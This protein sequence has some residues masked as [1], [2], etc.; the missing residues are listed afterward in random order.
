M[1][2]CLEQPTNDFLDRYHRYGDQI[3]ARLV[4]HAVCLSWVD[5]K[6]EPDGDGGKES[7]YSP[8]AFAVSAFVV[9]IRGIWFL[10]T[11]GHILKDLQSRLSSGRRILKSRLFAGLTS[12][13]SSE[14]IPFNLGDAPQWYICED[15]M[16]YAIIPFRPAFVNPLIAD[17]VIALNKIHWTN[18]PDN[19]GEYYLLGFP[20][21]AQKL[22]IT[23][24]GDT[25]NVNIQ[26]GCPLLPVFPVSDPPEALKQKHERFYAKVPFAKGMVDDPNVPLTDIDGMS[27]GPIFVLKWID[28]SNIESWVFAVQ[29]SWLKSSRI[30]AACP[31]LPLTNAIEKSIDEYLKN[32]NEYTTS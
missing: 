28:D 14:S 31:I 18:Y 15:G 10:V 24:S 2:M 7:D 21:Q 16:D 1:A 6:S 27:G 13:P 30:L 32:T 19:N 23:S 20:T 11:A 5:V 4:K 8:Q 12:T 25:G 26:V 3:L 29:S 9:S 17:G 22:S